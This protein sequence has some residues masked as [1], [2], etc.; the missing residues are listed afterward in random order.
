M[1]TAVIIAEY[2]PF[3]KGHQW[4]IATLRALGCS[5][6]IAIVSGNFVQ[7]AEP[8]IFPKATRCKAALLGGVDLVL[9]LPLP[10]ACATAQRF[11][12]GAVSLANACGCA[13]TLCFGSECGD[14]LLLQQAADFLLDPHFHDA[15]KPFLSQGMTF[16]KARTLALREMGFSQPS[17]L[18]Q[19]N[20]TLAIEYLMQLRQTGSSLTPL[21][22]ERQGVGHGESAP[23]EGFA[24]AS[25]IRSLLIE[26]KAD[27]AAPFLAQS[28]AS[29]LAQQP[30]VTPEDRIF[31]ARLRTLSLQDLS[32]LPDCSE[33]IEHRLH[34]AIRTACSMEELYSLTKT[35]R[36]SLARIRR[37]AMSAFLK[38]PHD[39]HRLP[40]PYLRVLGFTKQGQELLCK[41]RTCAELPVSGS[42][43]T[44]SAASPTA[45][46]FAQAEARSCD[47]YNL[48]EPT[49]L[50]C[51]QDYRFSPIRI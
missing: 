38:I 15:V 5:H 44:L 24:S 36:Y 37:L 21:T 28:S 40:P 13:D 46:R 16:A 50:P 35:K 25:Y 12:F 11:A 7:R 47:L 29:F 27:E 30:P 48:F 2:N 20:N 19:P 33:G 49:L 1:K 3:H 6:I 23:Q 41:M 34:H 39:L 32:S 31:L 10:Y 17:I 51:G 9:E 8:A 26:G 4:Q 43:A 18:E 22:L 42:L 14:L 45:K